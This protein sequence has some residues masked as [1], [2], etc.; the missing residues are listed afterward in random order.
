MKTLVLKLLLMVS[1][2]L[3]GFS[4]DR[5][6]MFPLLPNDAITPPIYVYENAFRVPL[7]RE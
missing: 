4:F 5:A 7:I 1:F 3:V 6:P 2:V